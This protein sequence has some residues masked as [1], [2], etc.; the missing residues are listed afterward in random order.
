MWS[1]DAKCYPENTP[2]IDPELFQRKELAFEAKAFCTDCPVRLRCLEEG[3]KP[4]PVIG[5]EY[6]VW[7]G[8][9]LRERRK[10]LKNRA[11]IEELQ[12]RLKERL[13]GGKYPN[14]S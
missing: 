4:I 1:E 14:V 3:L 11:K 9:T 7:G 8:L 12:A 10:V 2:S 5:L 13:Q 6:G